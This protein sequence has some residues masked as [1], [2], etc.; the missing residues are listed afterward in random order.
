MTNCITGSIQKRSLVPVVVCAI[1]LRRHAVFTRLPRCSRITSD[2]FTT[3]S[4]AVM[5]ILCEVLCKLTAKV[6]VVFTMLCLFSSVLYRVVL[7]GVRF[8]VGVAGMDS[9]VVV[10]AVSAN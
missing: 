10:A 8:P 2:L 5:Y 1:D 6:S 9:K 7:A 3:A 4:I